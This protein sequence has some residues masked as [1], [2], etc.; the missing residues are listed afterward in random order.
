[1]GVGVTSLDPA[2]LCTGLQHWFS[3]KLHRAS[4]IKVSFNGAAEGGSSDTSFIDVGWVDGARPIRQSLVLRCE[5]SSFR[6]Y[7]DPGIGR[8]VGV[9]NALRAE[10]SV[11]VPQVLW[12]EL[13]PGVLGTPFFLMEK[14]AGKTLPTFPSYNA[15]GW[16]AD[17]TPAQREQAWVSAVQTLAL[18]HTV[19]AKWFS[20]LDSPSDGVS[21]LDQQ[22]SYWE[23]YEQTQLAQPP[24]EIFAQ[25]RRWLEDNVPQEKPTALS[26]GDAR[27]GNLMFSGF[28]CMA[29]LDWETVSLGGAEADLGW[30]LFYDEFFSTGLGLARLEGLGDRAA[31][32]ALWEK[33]TG[34]RAS[35]LLFYD[36]FAAYRVAQTIERVVMLHAARGT[37]LPVGSGDENPA[38]L[39]LA[40][41]MELPA[42]RRSHP[43][44][45]LDIKEVG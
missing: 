3:T 26:W 19:D 10:G 1:M 30:W 15:S 36:I 22:L 14:I 28:E 29:V 23:R 21:G 37:A 34:R 4:D 16:L 45:E 41:L 7:P 9:L 5:P 12:V 13:N 33:S 6:V 27:L 31:T 38:I 43:G 2:T 17:A 25:A 35:N 18:V 42:R 11:P 24:H 20:F 39:V 44:E 8:Q 40:R 32:V